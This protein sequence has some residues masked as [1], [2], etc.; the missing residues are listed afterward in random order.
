MPL[1]P[2]IYKMCTKLKEKG[3][4]SPL[5]S[6]PCWHTNEKIYSSTCVDIWKLPH[7]EG[8]TYLLKIDRD[9]KHPSLQSQLLLS[10]PH[11]ISQPIKPNQLKCHQQW[12]H[13]TMWEH[14]QLRRTQCQFNNMKTIEQK[15]KK[16]ESALMRHGNLTVFHN[17]HKSISKPINQSIMIHVGYMSFGC[18]KWVH[19]NISLSWKLRSGVDDMHCSLTLG[20]VASPCI[21]CFGNLNP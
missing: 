7:L 19:I 12:Q 5:P 13:L 8:E 15:T 16:H 20:F 3:L 4:Q 6:T 9:K 11:K 18:S 21:C 10:Q 2:S 17:S 14:N 1:T